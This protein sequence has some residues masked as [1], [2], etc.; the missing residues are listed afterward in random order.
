MSIR[1]NLLITTV[2][3]VLLPLSV[4]IAT[5]QGLLRMDTEIELVA[6]EFSETRLLQPVDG[7][8][9]VAIVALRQGAGQPDGDARE[10]LERAEATLLHYLAQQFDSEA[11]AAHQA[12]E[13]QHAHDTLAD[14]RDLIG[15]TWDAISPEER[16]DRALAIRR[17][18]RSLYN[19]AD[20]GVMNAQQA[21]ILIEE[22]T[23]RLVVA[24]S[25]V[26]AVV[27]ILLSTW[28]NRNVIR[29]VHELHRNVLTRAE[30]DSRPRPR[31]VDAA[32]S[33]IDELSERMHL[34]L[35]EKNRELLRRER[36][37]GIGLLAADVAHEINNPMNA[38]L[39]LSELSLQTTGRG[40]ID[41]AARSELHE[42]LT[43]IRREAVRCKEIVERLMA[44]VRSR[45]DSQWFDATRL[46]VETVDVAR[47]SRPD[48]ARCFHVL[49]SGQP[50]QLFA[51]PQEVRQI[52]LTLLINAADAVA[53]DG[54]IEVDATRADGEVWLRVR[55]DGRGFTPEMQLD[56]PVALRT[57]RAREGGTGL[58]LSIAHTL[59][60]DI[61]AELRSFSDGPGKGSFFLLAI[62]TKEGDR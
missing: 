50:I 34:S 29:R 60:V 61:G 54:R 53:D 15:S 45:G 14:L 22:R 18:I 12:D 27:C 59:A 31:D 40:P 58:G 33:E 5:W 19:D 7:D 57:N 30:S 6:E 28:S 21:A 13:S 41:E 52:V 46:L 8:L 49:R 51:P 3:I 9:N 38:V 17:G 37:A 32:V 24:V 16:L 25:L 23:M 48:K 26:S 11:S 1:T 20:A 4:T 39:G 62:P 42:S 2:L 35:Q 56:F 47:A 44:M 36:I 55:D 10:H 43:V